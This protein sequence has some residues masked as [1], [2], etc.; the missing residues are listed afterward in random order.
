MF[1]RPEFVAPKPK[2]SVVATAQP[3]PIGLESDIRPDTRASTSSRAQISALV[4]GALESM[5]DSFTLV[6]SMS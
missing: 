1:T 3:V 4:M 5:R 2:S 6:S